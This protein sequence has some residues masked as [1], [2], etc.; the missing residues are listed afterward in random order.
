MKHAFS[1]VCLSQP[2]ARSWLKY[3]DVDPWTPPSHNKRLAVSPE[4]NSRPVET[5][6]YHFYP[7]LRTTWLNHFKCFTTWLPVGTS[8][9]W[10]HPMVIICTITLKQHGWI[11]LFKS[12]SLPDFRWRLFSVLVESNGHHLYRH[13]ETTWLNICK[14][15]TTWHSVRLSDYN[16]SPLD[17]FRVYWTTLS[18]CV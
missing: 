16:L 2:K 12:I 1:I 5:T 17:S 15:L 13:L 11:I 7:H 10:W 4:V 18:Q 6:N 3:K 8:Q 14:C 9:D